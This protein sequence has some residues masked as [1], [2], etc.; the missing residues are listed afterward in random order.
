VEGGGGTTIGQCCQCQ[1]QQQRIRNLP[2]L[3]RWP[4]TVQTASQEGERTQEWGSVYML[5]L[6]RIH[7]PQ[8][9]AV[10]CVVVLWCCG[11]VVLW[12]CGVVCC[13]ALTHTKL[14]RVDFGQNWNVIG[15]CAAVVHRRRVVTGSG[16]GGESGPIWNGKNALQTTQDLQEKKKNGSVNQPSYPCHSC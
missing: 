7:I 13:V 3:Y 10:S 4:S 6:L 16:G 14:F 8:C 5:L 12:C 1:H 2:W 15:Q 9:V 11:V